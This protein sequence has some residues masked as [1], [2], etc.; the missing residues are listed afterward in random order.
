MPRIRFLIAT[1]L[2][3]LFPTTRLFSLK[4]RLLR[5]AGV[6]VGEGTRIHSRAHLETSHVRLGRDVWVGGA[7]FISGNPG[8]PVVIGDRVDIAPRVTLITGTHVPGDAQRRAGE[9]YARGINIGDGTWLGAGSLVLPG[10]NIGEGV[11]VAAGSVVTRDVP[12]HV[13]VAGVPARIVKE[14]E[15]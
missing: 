8:A 6:D 7:T 4:R 15:G 9:G 2:L 13:L 5:W 3:P 12:P 1:S 10:V 14:L 11:I